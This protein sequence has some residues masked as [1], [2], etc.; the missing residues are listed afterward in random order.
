MDEGHF[1]IPTR[2]YLTAEQRDRLDRL[3]R[4]QELELDELLSAL[5]VAYLAEQPEPP[6]ADPP[7]DDTA[8]LL[9]ARRAELR[10]LRPKLSD[11]HN[12][13]PPWLTAMAAELETEIARLERAVGDGKGGA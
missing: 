2:I 4:H 7:A 5:A 11:R 1:T 13:P 3:L 10:R 12:P 8:E 9:R 6:A